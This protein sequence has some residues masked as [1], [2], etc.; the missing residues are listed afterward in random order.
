[1]VR[2]HALCLTQFGFDV[3][4][5]AAHFLEILINADDTFA[6]VADTFGFA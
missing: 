6:L 2:R 1:M 5:V 4:D 3:G